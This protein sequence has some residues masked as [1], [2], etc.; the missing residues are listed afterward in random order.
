[1]KPKDLAAARAL[2]RD[3][4]L[5]VQEIATRLG[6]AP[7]TLYASLPGGRSALSSNAQSDPTV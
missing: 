2:L 3:P 4:E 6:V 7:S 1:M 5:T